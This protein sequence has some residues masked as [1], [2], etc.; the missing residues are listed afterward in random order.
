M[1]NRGLLAVLAACLCGCATAPE[2]QFYWYRAGADSAQFS[3]ESA[4]CR[5]QAAS[6]MG[7]QPIP[8]NNNTALAFYVAQQRNIEEACLQGKGWSLRQR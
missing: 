6:A 3:L 1:L 8:Y 2:P 4:Q 5:A 7:G